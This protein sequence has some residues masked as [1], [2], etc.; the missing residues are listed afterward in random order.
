MRKTLVA[1]ALLSALSAL[2][3]AHAQASKPAPAYT[4]TGNMTLASE[5]IF[6]GIGQTNRK[7]AIQGG[8]DYVHTSGF[9]AGLWASNIS[10][11]SDA[12]P[13]VSAA[14]EA[15]FYGGYKGSYKSIS[16]DI[17]AL[18]YYY[19]GS[20]PSSGYT[21]PD[22]LELYAAASWKWFTLKY[23][24][25]VSNTFGFADSKGSDYIDLTGT[26]DVGHGITL[27]GHVGHQKIKNVTDASYT[28]WK[29][30][31]SKDYAGL[32]WGL[33]YIDTDAKGDPGQ[34]YQN[35]YGKDLGKARGLLTVGK[36]F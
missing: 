8:V 19:P 21:D 33:A 20:F 1:A 30:G 29:I 24:H 36:T 28:D 22:T 16:Y 5:Y 12:T 9:Y 34:P 25:A 14:I 15:D 17:G 10:W 18:Q 31:V 11:L 4:V 6:R 35:A 7:A 27:T 32:T 26:Y 2:Q 23:S 3:V 13:G